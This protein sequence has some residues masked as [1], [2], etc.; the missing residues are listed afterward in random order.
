M[1]IK[2][3]LFATLIALVIFSCGKKEE[4]AAA[5]SGPMP[6][7][8]LKVVRQDATTYQVMPPILKASRM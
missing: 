8:V 4:Q 5:P 3:S 7:P 1:H 2:Q 6:F